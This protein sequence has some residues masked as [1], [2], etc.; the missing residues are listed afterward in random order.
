MKHKTI[1]H[2]Q[3]TS[4]KPKEGYFMQN[5]IRTILFHASA[6]ALIGGGMALPTPVSAQVTAQQ[7][8]IQSR[9]ADENRR[10]LEQEDAGSSTRQSGPGVITDEINRRDLPPS[11][12]P[13]VLL[14]SVTIGPESAFLT[15]EELAPIAAK[16]LSLIHI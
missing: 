9:I 5:S 4:L 1:E 8:N 11:G 15:Q 13:T 3:K 10:R 7:A 16:Y 12:G 6:A 2:N 14:R